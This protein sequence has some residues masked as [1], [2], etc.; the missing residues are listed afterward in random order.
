MYAIRSLFKPAEE[1][2]AEYR[3]NFRHLVLDIGWF[4][5]LNGSSIS[6]LSVYATRLGASPFQVGLLGAMPAVM[7][8]ILAIPSGQWLGRR[9]IGK[10]VF[11]T[12][13]LYRFGY[14]LWV[15][16]PWLLPEAQQV[17]ALI[18]LV[19]LMGIPGTAL[20]VGFNAL[21][22]EA[23][24]PNWRAYVAGIRN[25][26]LSVTFVL[27]SLVS[28]WLL[29]HVTFPMGYQMVFALGCVGAA[30]SSYHLFHVRPA[31]P[32]GTPRLES[33]IGDR[34]RPG[35]IRAFGDSNR[36]SIG[37]RLL[38]RA[39]WRKLLRLDILRSSFSRV[40]LVLL[41]FHL[42]QYLAIPIFPIYVVR[43]LHLTDQQIGIGQAV[44]YATVMLGSMQLARLSRRFSNRAI[45]GVSAALMGIYPLLLAL[46]HDFWPYLGISLWGGLI[47]AMVGGAMPN[48]LLEKVPEGDRPSHL[49]WYN[50]VLNLAVLAGSLAGPLVAGLAGLSGALLI[51]AAL[52]ILSG[53]AV[54]KWG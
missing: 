43:E 26:M 20:A 5:I 19:L 47:W 53:L 52:R 28:G 45:F 9:P 2:P 12:S 42:A 21:F 54:L 17:W 50:I 39:S 7:S 34:A 33:R 24:P 18:V 35:F 6:F 30:M 51:I 49:A 31:L 15:P 8:L 1:I 3:A 32:P 4:G 11:W 48:Y 10:A 40:M 36:P 16:L 29:D 27:T 38:A 41:A 25:V 44:F 14:L 46:S 13:V 37:L 22:A 23:V